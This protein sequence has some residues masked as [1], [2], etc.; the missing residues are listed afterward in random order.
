[1]LKGDIRH[2]W[3]KGSV[4]FTL[5]KRNFNKTMVT[6]LGVTLQLGQENGV[7]K[8]ADTTQC[9]CCCW[10]RERGEIHFSKESDNEAEEETREA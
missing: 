10:Y 4:V 7:E 3:P 1:M 6:E 5:I 8:E 2:S 9:S